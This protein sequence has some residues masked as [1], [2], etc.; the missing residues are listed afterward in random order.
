MPMLIGMNDAS[1]ESEAVA[2][3][4]WARVR[5]LIALTQELAE[6]EALGELEV[7]GQARL[8]RARV[9]LGRAV[10]RA[11]MADALSDQLADVTAARARSGAHRPSLS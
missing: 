5:R 8:D 9:R 1:N 4:L 6:A 10:E 2:D 7:D 3:A 11:Q